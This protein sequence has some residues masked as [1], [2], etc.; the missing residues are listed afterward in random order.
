MSRQKKVYKALN[1]KLN[2]K[3]WI[4]LDEHCK[5]TGTS[6]TFVVEKAVKQLLNDYQSQ[7]EFLE[8]F[9]K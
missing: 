3:I 7:K 9:G 6:K 4:A 5:E 1:C 2:Q 8:K